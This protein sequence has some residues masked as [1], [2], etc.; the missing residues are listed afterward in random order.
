MAGRLGLVHLSSD[1]V[2]KQLAGLN[3][4][5]EARDAFG[6][7]LYQPAMTRRMYN[8]LTHRA[9]QWLRRGHSVVLDATY[10]R[11]KERAAIRRLARRVGARLV[12]FVW[13]APDNVLRHRLASCQNQPAGVSDARLELW[14]QPRAAFAEPTE[15]SEVFTISSARPPNKAVAQAAAV[16]T[17]T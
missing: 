17:G 4:K 6:E 2:Q 10:G 14:P 1:I 5:E 7:G 12:P 11:L 3:P 16:L 9:R 15:L 13:R 8:A